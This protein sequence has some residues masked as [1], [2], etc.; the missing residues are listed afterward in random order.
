M[1][2]DIGN[3]GEA[4]LAAAGYT[5]D[6]LADLDELVPHDP[7]QAPPNPGTSA[8]PAERVEPPTV[9]GVVVTCESEAELLERLTEEGQSVRALM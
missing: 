7:E 5:G 4:L 6:D 3:A 1:L 2:T 8:G 9:W